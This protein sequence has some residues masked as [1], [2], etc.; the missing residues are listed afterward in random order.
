MADG[1]S[2]HSSCSALVMTLAGQENQA[3][4]PTGQQVMFGLQ[5]QLQ[6]SCMH[7]IL[8]DNNAANRLS[9][10]YT[11]SQLSYTCHLVKTSQLFIPM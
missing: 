11:P 2:L 3:Y 10:L 8:F 5:P 6:A 7:H 4:M 1:V 9:A